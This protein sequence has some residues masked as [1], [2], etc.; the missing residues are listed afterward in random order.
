MEEKREELLELLYQVDDNL[1]EIALEREPTSKEIKD[2]IRRATIALKF[3][4]I[5]MGSAY[6]N[7]GVQTLLDGVVDFLPNPTEVYVATRLSPLPVAHVM[8]YSPTVALDL[9]NNE[10]EVALSCDHSKPFV[11]LAFKL[12]ESK[13]GQ[14]TYMRL[15]QGC[16]KRGDNIENMATNKKL[17]V[18]RLVRMHSDEMEEIS[19]VGSGE[20]CA[21][22]G[23]ECSSGTTFT[24]GS[25]KYSMVR[26]SIGLPSPFFHSAPHLV[27]SPDFYVHTGACDIPCNMAQ[28][29]RG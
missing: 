17:K 25:V 7:K 20:I 13:F 6:K 11:G 21:I 15:Y 27:L 4:P 1:T 28:S 22:F 29:Q 19:E 16:L 8:Q 10:K 12:E 9:A 23:V 2:A 18:P 24:D 14:L 3:S 5:F 26:F